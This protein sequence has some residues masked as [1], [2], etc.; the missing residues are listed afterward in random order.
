MD[1]LTHALLIAIPLSLIGRPDLAIYGIMGAVLIDVDVFFGL[2]SGR[3]PR[4]YIFTHGGFTHSFF[5]AFVV[6]LFAAALAYPLSLALPSIMAPVGLPAIAVI[7][8]GALTHIMVDYLA[9]PGIPLL[10]P[11]TDKKY[12]LGILAGPSIYIMA[13]SFTYIAAMATGYASMGTPWP[14]IAFFSLVIG[15]CAVSKAAAALRVKGRTIATMNPLRWLVVEDQPDAYR[16][17]AYDLLKGATPGES[18]KKLIGLAPPEVKIYEGL[19]EIKRLRYN[20]Y[21]VTAE[22]NGDTVTFSDPIREKG[23]IWYPPDFKS[24]RI[25]VR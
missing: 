4:L 18:Y 2:F 17:Y 1:S 21:I 12:T 11:A 14:F 9:Y 22:K 5:G 23:H 6:T 8:A 3:D 16:F 25:V 13:A 24:H 20:S 7:A 19:P 15:I 10:Y